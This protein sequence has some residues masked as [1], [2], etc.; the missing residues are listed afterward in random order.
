MTA[1]R[2]PESGTT[3]VEKPA[4]ELRLW[5]ATGFTVV[6]D[7]VSVGPARFSSAGRGRSCR[8]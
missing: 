5:I 6:E 2:D 1:R 3:S 4:G 7:I 8:L